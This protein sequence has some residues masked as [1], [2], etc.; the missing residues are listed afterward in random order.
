M[1]CLP[2]GGELLPQLS[3]H[4]CSLLTLSTTFCSQLDNLTFRQALANILFCCPVLGLCLYLNAHTP[5]FLACA[6]AAI[7]CSSCHWSAASCQV[8]TPRSALNWTASPSAGLWQALPCCNSWCSASAP[9][10][11]LPCPRGSLFPAYSCW[12]FHTPT[13]RQAAGHTGKSGAPAPI[14]PASCASHTGRCNPWQVA[15]SYSLLLDL[16]CTDIQTRLLGTR[17][18]SGKYRRHRPS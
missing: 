13:F 2:K 8:W 6:G 12:T 7:C 18:H 10:W 11:T 14:S 3:L 17:E 16:S 9:H 4:C 15:L 1:S 5:F